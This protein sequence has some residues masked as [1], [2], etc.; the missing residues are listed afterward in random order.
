MPKKK[1]FEEVFAAFDAVGYK[2]LDNTYVNSKTSINYVCDKGHISKITWFDFN[3]GC[4]CRKCSYDSRANKRKKTFGEVKK[5]F[6]EA[7]FELLSTSY[8]NRRSS[9]RFLC[10]SGHLGS[11]TLDNVME[12]KRCKECALIK[13]RESLRK[14]FNEVVSFFNSY[15]YKILSAEEEY[16]NSHTKVEFECPKGHTDFICVYHFF[17][18]SRCTYCLNRKACDDNCLTTV[19]PDIAKEWHPTKNGRLTA[20]D[21]VL[22][23]NKRVWWLC[24]ECGCEWRTAVFNRTKGGGTRC[25]VCVAGSPVSRT[26]QE[27]LDSLMVS[28]E[29]RE[30]LLPDLKIRVDAFDHET[31]TVYEFFGDYWHG[32]PERFDKNQEHPVVGKTFGQL[33]DETKARIFRLE[34]AGYKVVY[35]WENDFKKVTK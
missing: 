6:N 14:P 23:S 32:N 1:T 5:I 33:Y 9:L 20:N 12:G 3:Q 25:P 11:M 18:G 35:I 26:S 2:V 4:R 29:K 17:Q 10:E 13:S 28:Q 30:F 8:K 7:G 24:E 34:E 22:G 31:N 15:G 27:W 21:V 19:R 16:V